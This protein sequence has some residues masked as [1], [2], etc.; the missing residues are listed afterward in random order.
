MIE[1][2]TLELR[3]RL[4]ICNAFIHLNKEVNLTAVKVKLSKE[5]IEITI[6][7]KTVIFLMK[8]I[9][10]IPDSLSAL[11][12]TKNWIC[13]RK[14]HI[15]CTFCKNILS[16]DMYIKRILPVPD[17]NCDPSEWFCCKHN[18]SKSDIF[19]GSFFFIIHASLFNHNLKVEENVVICSKCLH[20]LGKI[21]T[22]N[23]F[24]LWNCSVDYNSLS[25]STIKNATDPFNDFLLAIKTSMT[26][27]LGEE[28]I[29][30]YFMGKET[31]SLTIKPMDWHLNLMIEPKDILCNNIVTLQRA[32]VVKVL[33]KYETNKNTPDSVNKTYCEAGLEHL[34]TSTKRFPQ[35]YRT[36]I[37]YNVG[38]I[39]LD[40]FIDN[41]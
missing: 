5:N 22:D 40:N 36:A 39:C 13:F 12:V 23:S 18:H 8:F 2:M 31:H 28:I 24:K 19:Y 41:T 3:P 25:N 35:V 30:Q 27:I 32:S 16:K 9:K 15:M 7:N 17:M 20:Y 10:L 14:C 34:L 11:D 29:L 26:G 38:Y 37:D 21:H 4:Q 6:E 1:S 33:Y